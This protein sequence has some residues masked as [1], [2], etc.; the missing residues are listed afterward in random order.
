MINLLRKHFEEY[1]DLGFTARMEDALDDISN[2]KQYWVDFLAAFYRGEGQ[3]GHG[4]AP[5]IKRELPGI[6]F[7]TV[8]VGNDPASGEPI[9]VRVGR[10]SPFVQRGAGGPEN[11][12]SIPNDVTYE[13]LTVEKALALLR[14]KEGT[15]A[16][17]GPHPSTGEPILALLGPYGPYVQLGDKTETNQKPKRASLPKG[18]AL[19]EVTVEIALQLLSLPRD[20]GTHPENGQTITSAVGRFGPFV[21][22]GEEFRSLAAGDDVYTI[23][24]E[25]ALELLA[26]PKKSRRAT[27]TVMATLGE[28][29]QTKK[30]I[31]LCEGRYG[32]FVTNGQVNASIPKDAD[33]ATV[34]L[35][36]ARE[37]LA[38]A[39]KRPAKRKPTARA[40]AKPKAKRKSS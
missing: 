22:C 1:V 19:E 2:G 35:E 20:L 7:P 16:V 28:D 11:T 25:R 3:F 33:P 6:E 21:K 8:P 27:K 34:T 17:L 29:A 4:L 38:N 15:N 39:A 23:T 10:T 37:L 5:Q 9:V 24:R 18:M 40:K 26:Q 14:H 30:P 36:Q 12:A 32:P 31:E 13:E